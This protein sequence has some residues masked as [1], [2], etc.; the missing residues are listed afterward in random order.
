MRTR[1]KLPPAFSNLPDADRRLRLLRFEI[2]AVVG[3][4][5][6]LLGNAGCAEGKVA[7]ILD[8]NIK[9]DAAP[10]ATASDASTARQLVT[11]DSG[12]DACSCPPF[13]VAVM[14]KPGKWGANPE[15][16]PDTAL[17]QWLSSS[18]A[19]TARVDN[20]TQRTLLTADFLARYDLIILASLSDDSNVGPWWLFS[21]DEIAAF[22]A[23][24]ENGG[25]V[26]SMVGYS[27]NP[28]EVRPVNE[29]IGFSGITDNA[30]GVW[31]PST[32]SQVYY[33][34]Q[35]NPLTDWNRTD[36]VIANLSTG[37]TMV[38]FTN[39]HSI[40]APSDGHVVVS[41]DGKAVMVAKIVNQGRILAYG[42]EW[43]SYTSQWTGVGNPKAND[44][45]CD[46]YLAQDK[47]QMSQLWYNMIHWA[48]A[49]ATCFTIVDTA[50]P[51]VIW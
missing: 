6:A 33:C 28:D 32:D 19:G 17:Q 37:V 30:D 51:V 10:H 25:G 38:G 42:D 3:V 12:D 47:F 41:V 1:A 16:D 31:G 5:V 23:W 35:S 4:F 24:V 45:S 18:S 26:L 48:Q 21:Q 27:G 9:L 43:I 22:Q 29:L 40:N 36:P 50:V 15:G 14:G 11:C 39:G 49:R 8:L 44:P 2:A 13:N 20:F 7:I 34:N 46:G